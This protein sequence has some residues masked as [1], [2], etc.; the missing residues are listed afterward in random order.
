M[1]VAA[2]VLV[3]AAA[4][5]VDSFPRGDHSGEA[6]ARELQGDLAAAAAEHDRRRQR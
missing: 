1:I 4:V 2:V 3:A 5:I 6:L